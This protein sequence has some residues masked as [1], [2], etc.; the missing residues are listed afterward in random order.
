MTHAVAFNPTVVFQ[1]QQAFNF[2]MPHWIEQSGRTAT[3]A[4]LGTGLHC[5]LEMFVERDTTGMEG[6][7]ATDR[8]AQRTDAAGVDTDTGTLRNVFHNGAGGGVN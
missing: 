6:F 7:T 4:A 8:A 2:Q 5:G 1:H 3:H